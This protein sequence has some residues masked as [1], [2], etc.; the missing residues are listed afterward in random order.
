MKTIAFNDPESGLI[1]WVLDE[2]V[3][4]DVRPAQWWLWIGRVVV[5]H[6]TLLV[7]KRALV[8]YGTAVETFHLPLVYVGETP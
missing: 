6:R 7:G 3:V 4:V 8:L 5:N 2:G 1:E